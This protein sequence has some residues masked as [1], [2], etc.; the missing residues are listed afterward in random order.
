MLHVWQEVPQAAA[1]GAGGDAA[2]AVRTYVW[3]ACVVRLIV[4]SSR[5]TLAL[6][7]AE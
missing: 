5:G 7:L 4:A 2:K 6:V 1:E 3:M